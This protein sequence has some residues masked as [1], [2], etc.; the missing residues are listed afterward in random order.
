MRRKP[1]IIGMLAAIAFAGCT[2]LINYEERF[3]QVDEKVENLEERVTA[4]EELCRTMNSNISALQTLVAALQEND[5]ITSVS[6]ITEGGEVVGYTINFAKGESITIYHGEDGRD[7]TDGTN[8]TNGEDGRDGTSPVIGVRMDDD[9]IYY[10]TLNGE[11]LTNENGDRVQASATDGTDGRDGADG[12][13]PE[14]KIEDGYWFISYDGGASWTELGRASGEDGVNY[15]NFFQSIT[16]T[17]DEV[18]FTLA[19]G[20]TIAVL[21][22]RAF[23]LEIDTDRIDYSAGLS[24][25]IGFRVNGATPETTVELVASND[26]RA[27]LVSYALEDS[28][29]V[30]EICVDMPKTIVEHATV[31][32]LVSD[33]RSKVVMKS[34]HFDYEGCDDIEDGVL[35]ITS[36]EALD[37]PVE[38]GTLSVTLQTNL[39]YRVELD[40]SV[41]EWLTVAETRAELRQECLTFTAAA[42]EGASRNGFVYLINMADNSIAQTLYVSQRADTTQLD[43]VITFADATFESY[44]IANF[45]LNKDG[46][47]SRGEALEV[48]SVKVPTSVADLSGLE[49]CINLTSLN[50]ESNSK[51]TSLNTSTLV[52]LETLNI[53]SSKITE[54]DLSHNPRLRSLN[55]EWAYLESLDVSHNNELEELNARYLDDLTNYSLELKNHPRLE[56]VNLYAS[57]FAQLDVT[58]CP[59]LYY[60]SCYSNNLT[61]LDLSK[62]EKLEYL[63]CYYNSLTELDLTANK[64]LIELNCSSN[65]LTSLDLHACMKLRKLEFSGNLLTEVNMGSLPYI[66]SLTINTYHRSLYTMKVTGELLTSLT[67]TNDDASS[68][69]FLNGF[70]LDTPN[71]KSLT[72]NGY[73]HAVADF[74]AVPTVE[75]LSLSS[76]YVCDVYLEKNK[77][78]TSFRLYGGKYNRGL[79]DY[80]KYIKS[81]DFSENTNLQSITISNVDL[82]SINVKKCK[83]LKSLSLS[84]A[85]V[86]P[87]DLSDMPSL[88]TIVAYNNNLGSLDVSGCT[89]LSTIECYGDKLT[90]INM[91]GCT[92]LATLDCRSNLLTALSVPANVRTIDCSSNQ[93]ETLDLRDCTSLETLNCYNNQLTLLRVPTDIQ[94]LNCSNNQLTTLDLEGCVAVKYVNCENNLFETLDVSPCV[95]MTSLNCS[96][97]KFLK[98]LYMAEGQSIEGITYRRS[99][100]CIPEAT[101]IVV[102]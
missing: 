11:W 80:N 47:L 6:P 97:N 88:E 10:W 37:F 76:C 72:V 35:Y 96:D 27:T 17:D 34:I 68:M 70:D 83:S 87:L 2:D 95:A 52:N 13:T 99:T 18:L 24:Y 23:S 48:K 39:S 45:D 102:K 59:N 56:T 19:D 66:T 7:G 54:I 65:K 38:G 26:L 93:F 42:N 85:Y 75:A 64:N 33:G 25:V 79:V 89:S 62:C 14:L 81:L 55:V 1:I 28:V 9:G 36:G 101:E 40:A 32:V 15:C 20:S 74:S 86:S 77:A 91:S 53:Y 98:I 67:I 69:F 46:V 43:E 51:L 73:Y 16:E 63:D 60:L 92:S 12:T 21:K 57:E 84:S 41:G 50:C 4:L 3:N 58:G 82:E 49:Y 61:E 71:L 8:G 31:A 30:G 5:C 78:L 22:E 100:S 29:G 44:M 94:G 90:Y